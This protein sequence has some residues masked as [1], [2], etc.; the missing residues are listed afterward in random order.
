M[1][2][3][4]TLPAFTPVPRAKDRS[5]GWKPVVQRQFIEALAECGSVRG[6]AE[7]VGRTPEGAYQ[8]RRHPQAASF[9]AAW[10]A[11]LALANAG[12]PPPT[13]PPMTMQELMLILRAQKRRE[14]Q[15]GENMP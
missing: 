12:V 13:L 14:Q 6:A 9:R 11:A 1:K 4:T 15:R 3:K 7:S 5:N 10:H 2:P 8:L